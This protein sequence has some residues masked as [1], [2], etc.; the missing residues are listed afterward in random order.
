MTTLEQ[1]AIDWGL[2]NASDNIVFGHYAV[3]SGN[4]RQALRRLTVARNWQAKV[5]QA[6]LPHC[7]PKQRAQILTPISKLPSPIRP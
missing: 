6:L 7:T 2:K 5:A 3:A 1:K 4:Y